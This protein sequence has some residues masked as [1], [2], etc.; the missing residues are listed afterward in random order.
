MS[1]SFWAFIA[2]INDPLDSRELGFSVGHESSATNTEPGAAPQAVCQ[3]ADRVVTQRN[4]LCGGAHCRRIG[5][6]K[7]AARMAHVVPELPA[8]P[9]TERLRVQ[10]YLLSGIASSPL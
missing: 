8:I 7:E 4:R 6:R 2:K 3:F 10:T 5:R 1:P 9:V